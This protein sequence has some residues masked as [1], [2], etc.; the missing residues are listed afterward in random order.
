MREKDTVRNDI[1]ATSEFKITFVPEKLI[2]EDNQSGLK[3]GL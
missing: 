3:A 2:N 1:T